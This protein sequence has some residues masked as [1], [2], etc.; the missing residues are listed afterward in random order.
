MQTIV[1]NARQGLETSTL[2]RRKAR[3]PLA[4]FVLFLLIFWGGVAAAILAAITR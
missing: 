2:N 3:G 4:G 1:T